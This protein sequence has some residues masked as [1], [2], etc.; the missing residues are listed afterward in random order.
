MLPTTR[1][2]RLLRRLLGFQKHMGGPRDHQEALSTTNSLLQRFG[3]GVKSH[4]ALLNRLGEEWYRQALA[5]YYKRRRYVV[6]FDRHY[7][8][9]YYAYDIAATCARRPLNRRIHGFFLKYLY[10]K[11][12]LIIYLDA[13]ADVLFARKGEGTLELLE[14][15]RA[16]Y[17]QIK[18]VVKHFEIVD[19]NQCL[20]KVTSETIDRIC[21]FHQTILG[22]I[23]T[24]TDAKEKQKKD[25]AYNPGH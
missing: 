19:A 22:S 11:P 1:A 16:D 5:W 24:T 3:G 23:K 4:L 6:L 21:D 9:D 17:L 14:R 7:F 12:D 20:A 18:D 15:R 10:P 8:V 2:I 25:Y 13:P